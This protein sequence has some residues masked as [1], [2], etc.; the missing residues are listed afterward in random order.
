[1]KPSRFRA[2]AAL[3][4]TGFV[5]YGLQAA[6]P[7]SEPTDRVIIKWR[8]APNP[9][10]IAGEMVQQLGGRLGRRLTPGRTIGGGMSVVTLDRKRSGPELQAVLASLRADPDV[11]LAEVD[12]RVKAQAYVPNDPNF[13]TGQWYLK[14]DQ[15]AGLRADAAWE[16]T[17]GGLSAATSAVVVAVID[18]GVRFDH[19]DLAGKL[20][21]GY[22]FISV[23]ATSGDGDSWD[24][25]PSD[26]G[27]F[28]SAQ[29]LLNDTFKNAGCGSGPNKDQPTTSSWHGT[30]V[31]GIVAANTDNGV[32]MAGTGFNIR[33]LPARALGKCGGFDS[34]VMAAMYW[35][36][37]MTL[38]PALLLRTDLPVNTT[39][40][41]VINLSLG[42]KGACN[43]MYSTTVSDITAHGVLIVASAGNEGEA[44]G[45]PANCTGVMAV[46]GVRHAGTK[47]GYSDLGSRV[48]ISAPAGNCVNVL[49]GEPCLY[50]LHTTTN[51]GATV[52]GNNIYTDQYLRPNYGTSFA[53]PQAA[54]VAGL[55]KAVNPAL[56][57]AALIARI[58]S[59]A[60]PFPTVSDTNPQ[61]PACLSPG[62]GLVQGFECICNTQVCGAGLLFAAGA[63]NEALRPI[64]LAQITGGISAGMSVTLDG[65]PSGVA[66]GRTA[67]YQWSVVSV[68]DGASTPTIQNATQAIAS[69]TAPFAGTVNMRLTVTDNL[70]ASDFADVS[71]FVAARNGGSDTTAPPPSTDVGGGGGALGWPQLLLLG[72]AGIAALRR[73]GSLRA[74]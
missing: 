68:A 33:V 51:D 28:L 48:S 63:V 6:D 9:A 45:T 65:S 11:E 69:V 46:A 14:G 35:A 24:P 12:G 3:L 56:T 27:D 16:V 34:D 49:P 1:M 30:R 55:M 2:L 54:G 26:A 21:A 31:S 32:G 44:V 59:S 66:V 25:D 67:S 74:H 19:P 7:S 64:A 61:P 17:K 70:G 58:R 43:A 42:S 57:P 41:Q 10:S 37:G 72:A 50:Q 53:S 52:P 22:D 20:L 23:P 15:Q 60:R 13:A 38:P 18:T 71:I 29:D 39:P 36:A 8:N 73:R 40:A 5:S 4:I 47:V 62:G